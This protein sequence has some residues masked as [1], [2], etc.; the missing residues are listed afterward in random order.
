MIAVQKYSNVLSQNNSLSTDEIHLLFPGLNNLL[1]FQRK[2]LIQLE[3][4]ATKPW[5]DQRWGLV[6]KD[7]VSFT[8]TWL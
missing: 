4:T 8:A 7:N 2:F 6:F 1:E 5:E 3:T